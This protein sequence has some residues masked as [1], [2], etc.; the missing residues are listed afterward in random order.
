MER[1]RDF[2]EISFIRALKLFIRAPSHHLITSQRPQLLI[3]SPVG[4]KI[5]TG[6]VGGH[7]CSDRGIDVL[8][9]IEESLESL[10]VGPL[11]WL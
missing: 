4:A 2:C 7:R 3:P 1:A 10:V 8:G 5:S 6:I 9:E 11:V